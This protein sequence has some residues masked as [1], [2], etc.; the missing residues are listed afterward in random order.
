MKF[1]FSLKFVFF[2]ILITGLALGWWKSSTSKLAIQKRHDLL[3][4]DWVQPLE[5]VKFN[6]CYYRT[7]PEQAAGLRRWKVYV[8]PGEK[9]FEL[10]CAVDRVPL[11]RVSSGEGVVARIPLP[12]GNSL[13]E[14]DWKKDRNLVP[15]VSI[16]LL[17]PT[18]Q[19]TKKVL[20]Q[21]PKKFTNYLFQ[22]PSVYQTVSVWQ[23]TNEAIPAT[24][25]S[26]FSFVVEFND[27]T[28][29]PGKTLMRAEGFDIQVREVDD[30]PSIEAAN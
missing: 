24:N 7:L 5:P 26:L 14:V 8:P 29:N 2:S 18:P 12:P 28:T 15:H 9:K 1:Q 21:F 13:F 4:K 30:N 11:G 20:V 10:Q 6:K 16:S 27:T 25:F 17:A 19:D 3:L 23:A 22:R